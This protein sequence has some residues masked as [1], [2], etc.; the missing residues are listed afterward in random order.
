M[1][2]STTRTTTEGTLMA[3]HSL[4]HTPARPARFDLAAATAQFHHVFGLPVRTVATFPTADE[5]TLR[6]TLFAEE[7]REYHD[8]VGA[9]DLVEIADALADMA[10]VLSGTAHT[11]GVEISSA[12]YHEAD[13]DTG[14]CR[15]R[16]AVADADI[17]AVH[18]TMG[19]LMSSI[20]AAARTWQVPLDAVLAEV[21]RSNMSKLGPDGRPVLRADGKVQKGPQF[22]APDI[23][24]VLR[25]R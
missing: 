12:A 18:D 11:F 24:A 8:A 16:R 19:A 23:A 10:Y 20:E 22:F 15:Y 6:E 2:S 7:L 21:H 13:L 3:T 25:T 17:A 14:F 1:E 5:L 4:S 9:E